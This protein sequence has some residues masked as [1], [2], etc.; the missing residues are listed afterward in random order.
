MTNEMQR[1]AIYRLELK[2]QIVRNNPNITRECIR[3]F[4]T[5]QLEDLRFN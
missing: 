5:T 2:R 3:N 4:N 1:E